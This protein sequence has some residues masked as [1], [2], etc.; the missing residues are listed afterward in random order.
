MEGDVISNLQ[1]SIDN[2]YSY[3]A[4]N[5]F[6]QTLSAEERLYLIARKLSEE[7]KIWF[8]V[9]TPFDERFSEENVQQTAD[10]VAKLSGKNINLSTWQCGNYFF[11]TAM[12]M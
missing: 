7:N 10:Y 3:K 12:V 11:F 6:A 1:Q 9:M 8:A 4:L 2:R 5:E